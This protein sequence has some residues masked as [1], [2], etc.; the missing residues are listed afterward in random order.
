MTRCGHSYS[1]AYWLILSLS[2]GLI[3]LLM[4][5]LQFL[6]LLSNH[7]GSIDHVFVCMFVCRLAGCPP[8]IYHVLCVVS[9][10]KKNC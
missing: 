8:I 2:N 9:N 3:P 6:V 5:S 4:L 1:H 7:A 10:V